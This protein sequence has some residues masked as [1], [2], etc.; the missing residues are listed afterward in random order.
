MSPLASVGGGRVEDRA[1]MHLART[2][3]CWIR[4]LATGEQRGA[5]VDDNKYIREFLMKLR[6]SVL[7]AKAQHGEID[8]ILLQCL[9]GRSC[10]GS[11]LFLQRF[12]LLQQHIGSV[13]IDLLRMS[14]AQHQDDAHT[15]GHNPFPLRGSHRIPLSKFGRKIKFA[16]KLCQPDE[17]APIAGLRMHC[18]IMP[19]IH[20]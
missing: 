20:S 17:T 12:R 6:H 4:K 19:H 1:S 2:D 16:L 13:M 18:W 7:A 9:A 8:A 5:A 11:G 15:C 10:R 14:N 3:R